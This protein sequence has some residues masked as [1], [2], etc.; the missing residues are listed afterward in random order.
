MSAVMSPVAIC[1]DL[2]PNVLCHHCPALQVH[3]DRGNRRALCTI[4][5]FVC[6]ALG[7]GLQSW[8]ETLGG[9][10]GAFALL[11]S[12]PAQGGAAVNFTGTTS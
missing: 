2:A 12:Q 6:R 9:C 1:E 11:T 5:L 3:V 4:Q 7:C 10:H 8:E